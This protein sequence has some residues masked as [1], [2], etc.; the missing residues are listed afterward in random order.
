MTFDFF[1]KIFCINLE[2][3]TGRRKMMEAE[4]KS[5]GILDRVDFISASPPPLD[6]KMS[7]FHFRGEFGVNLS[8]MKA[9][10]HAIGSKNVLIFEDDITF[11]PN[12][13]PILEQALNCLPDDYGVFFLGGRPKA[14]LTK[15]SNTLARTSDFVQASSYCV[16][17]DLLVDFYDFF[18][19]QVTQPFP[20]GC[21]D[22]ILSD[23]AIKHTGYCVYP[24][25]AYQVAGQSSIREAH[26][27][28]IND[29]NKDWKQYAPR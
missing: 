15:I 19:E 23:F 2:K 17:G 1:D 4:F 29:T 3:D 9:I 7:N 11:I 8:Q 22:K 24:P 18:S 27:D 26:R 10:V 25:L 28:Y 20:E 12:A 6:F 21:Y 16:R 14:P 13:T 5:L